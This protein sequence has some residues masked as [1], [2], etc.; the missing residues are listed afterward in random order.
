MHRTTN[1][2]RTTRPAFVVVVL[3]I[4]L[5]ALTGPARAAGTGGIE[6]VPD[7][8]V[9]DGKTQTNFKVAV[10]SDGQERIAF[11]V[12]NTVDEPRTARLYAAE[13]TGSPREGDAL[14]LGAAES[15]NIVTLEPTTLT[16]QP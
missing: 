4:L 11:T 9:V 1:A 6:V 8:P 14:R 7:P 12:R 15:S 2:G 13:V 3:L 10:P 5:S 16:L